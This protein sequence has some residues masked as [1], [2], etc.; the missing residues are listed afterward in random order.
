MT[1]LIKWHYVF[2]CNLT[3]VWYQ[4]KI[5]KKTS[6][7]CIGI[8]NQKDKKIVVVIPFY[9]TLFILLMTFPVPFPNSNVFF[10]ISN[11]RWH[12]WQPSVWFFFLIIPE[13][14]IVK[15]TKTERMVTTKKQ[16]AKQNRIIL[17]FI[18]TRLCDYSS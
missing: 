15:I 1:F 12:C 10:F 14:S 7:G 3:V 8:T 5:S 11:Y 9:H 6:F 17:N 4:G 18:H 16:K 2:T 13:V